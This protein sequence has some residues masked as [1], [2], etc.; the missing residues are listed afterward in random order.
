MTA[1]TEELA[2]QAGPTSAGGYAIEVEGLSVWYGR[3]RA[4]HNLSMHVPY[5]SIYGLVGPSGAGKT[6]TMRVLATVQHPDEGTVLVDGV[7]LSV[8]A[9]A[10]R[11]RIGYLP[12]FPGVY[13]NLTV[14]EYLDFY[15]AIYRV[16]AQ[17][18]RQV[19]G[20]LLELMGLTDRRNNPVGSLPRGMK[21]KL[22]FCRCLIHDPH[23]L[24]LDEPAAGLDPRSRLDL[25]DML[26]ELARFGKSV[27]ISSHLL[28]ELAEVCTHLGVM[29]A[30]ELIAEGAVDEI[31][32][33]VS[34]DAIL[35]V[36]LLDPADADTAAR[37]IEAYPASR[38]V[39]AA[40][41]AT[42]LARFEG[43]DKDLAAIL[44]QLSRSGVRVTEIT[45]ERQTLEDVFLQVTEMESPL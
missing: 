13:G 30:G 45:I 22:G 31:V 32:A 36:R 37:L 19:G 3:T 16:P 35:R 38:Q 29:R 20:E 28:S 14:T 42:L 1:P 11:D 15:G 21:Q 23:I 33:A 44:G 2:G 8:D 10:A 24:L 6:T 5:G 17:R 7:D 25:R 4:L 41:P 9:A 40:D 43:A 18:R 26:Q 34:P 12:D 39:E 27:L